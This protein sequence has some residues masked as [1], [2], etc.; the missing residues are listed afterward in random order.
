[1]S[2]Q[3]DHIIQPLTILGGYGS[4]VLTNRKGTENGAVPWSLPKGD[5]QPVQLT[6]NEDDAAG[7]KTVAKPKTGTLYMV[8]KPLEKRKQQRLAPA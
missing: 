2:R 1:M 6:Y 3:D 4:G 7:K 8:A 5:K